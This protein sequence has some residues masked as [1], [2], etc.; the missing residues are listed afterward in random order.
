VSIIEI[1][2]EKEISNRTDF[3]VGYILGQLGVMEMMYEVCPKNKY[4]ARG[5]LAYMIELRRLDRELY[6]AVKMEFIDMIEEMLEMIK[7]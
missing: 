1:V 2:E 4:L 5:F 6:S 3:Q 7:E